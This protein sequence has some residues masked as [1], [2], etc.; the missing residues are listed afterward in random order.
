MGQPAQEFP[1]GPAALET[2]GPQPDVVAQELRDPALADTVQQQQRLVVGAPHQHPAGLGHG[3]DVTEPAAPFGRPGPFLG[4]PGGD[5]V[6]AADFRDGGLEPAFQNLP[7]WRRGHHLAEGRLVKGPDGR[8]LGPQRQQH[9]AAA[10]NEVDDIAQVRRR[11]NVADH[12]AVEDD[13]IEV[14]K[15]RLEQFLDRKGDQR[16]FLQGCEVVLFRR[17]ED[18]EMDQVHRRIGLQEVPPSALAGMG[19]ARNQQHPEPV[20]DAV[21][22]D[23]GAVVDGRKLALGGIHLQFHHCRPGV[24]EFEGEFVAPPHR[25]PGVQGLVVVVAEPD[26]GQVGCEATCLLGAAVLDPV[27]DRHLLADDAVAGRLFDHQ[28]AVVFAGPSRQQHMDRPRHRGRRRHVVNLA[29]GDH[30][31]AGKALAR[32]LQG[33]PGQRPEKPRALVSGAVRG[34]DNAD[35]QVIEPGE[36]QGDGRQRRRRLFPALADRLA[37]RAVDGDD[38]DVVLG[39]AFLPDRQRV[40]QR[41]H[42]HRQDQGPEHRPPSTPN[43]RQHHQSQGGRRQTRDYRPRQQGRQG[44]GVTH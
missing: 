22:A 24:I 37:G 2:A 21:D 32:H 30:D 5:R 26:V 3:F 27:A 25:H 34:L 35:L 12:I 8:E 17:A 14:G 29:V 10:V 9:R 19:L 43:Q 33:G 7:R 20:T 36:A 18:G 40:D 41:H 44:E 42:Q 23:Q 13:E 6:A 31:G 1:V 28:V 15:L 4:Q 16:Q 38:G 39:F 11:Q